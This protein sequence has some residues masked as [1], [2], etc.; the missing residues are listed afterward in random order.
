MNW[1]KNIIEFKHYLKLEKSLSENS[2]KAYERDIRKL[3]DFFSETVP[4]QITL[5]DLEH[6]LSSEQ[7]ASLADYS[8]ARLI[9]S[10][11]AFYRYLVYAELIAK[12]PSD[13]LESPK[14]QRYLPDVLSIKDID[15]MIKAIDLSHLHGTRDKAIMEMLYGCG[16]RVSELVALRIN[17]LYFNDGFVRIIG[18][19]N[20]ERLVPVGEPAK[21]AVN[22]YLK[23]IRLSLQPQKGD[24]EILFLNHRNGR[25]SRAAIFDLTKKLAMQAGI[26][27][28][29]S[30][31]SLRH[32]FATHLMEGGADIRSV[33]E[34]LGHASITTT[35]IYTHLDR[36]YL[37]ETLEQFHPRYGKKS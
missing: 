23:Y 26:R 35:E 29:V 33:Q 5:R 7:I 31:H 4:D 24:A 11:K 36:T 8:Q 6:F 17:D 32:S 20:K 12:N 3:A 15:A 30:P 34:M 1:E 18:K 14:L 19:G 10:I 27:K 28:R 22:L 13:L 16:L 9:S 37:R 2:V 25:L 21:K